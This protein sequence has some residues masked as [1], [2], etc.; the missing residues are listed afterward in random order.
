MPGSRARFLTDKMPGACTKTQN[1]ES[2]P[3]K[4]ANETTETSKIV[5]R[6]WIKQF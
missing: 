3:P 5:S 1:N 6:E 4:R 2:K